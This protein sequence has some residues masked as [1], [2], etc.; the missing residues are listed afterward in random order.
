MATR[1]AR[2]SSNIL[3]SSVMI[4]LLTFFVNVDRNVPKSATNALTVNIMCFVKIVRVEVL[5][6]LAITILNQLDYG[7]ER[8]LKLS[9]DLGDD[10][11]VT[12]LRKE[13]TAFILVIYRYKCAFAGNMLTKYVMFDSCGFST[14]ICLL[15]VVEA[16]GHFRKSINIMKNIAIINRSNNPFN[17]SFAVVNCNYN[18]RNRRI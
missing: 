14:E 18:S 15:Q 5:D 13:V 2:L 1:R 16:L 17:R 11:D 12:G 4:W 10:V 9:P 6:F 7:A 8:T 3:L